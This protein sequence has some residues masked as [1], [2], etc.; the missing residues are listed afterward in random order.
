MA[1]DNVLN[2]KLSV[3]L[4]EKQ[5]HTVSVVCNGCEALDALERQAFD[6]VVMDVQMPGMDGYVSKPIRVQDLNSEIRRLERKSA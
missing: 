2:Q 1:E 6:L 4:I 5:G 3:R